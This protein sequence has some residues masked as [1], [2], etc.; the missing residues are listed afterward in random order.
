MHLKAKTSCH[1]SVTYIAIVRSSHSINYL[2][3]AFVFLKSL[4]RRLINIV[5]NGEAILLLLICLFS[6]PL[7]KKVLGHTFQLVISHIV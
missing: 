3:K 6:S 2:R 7:K 5:V 4:M 1:N